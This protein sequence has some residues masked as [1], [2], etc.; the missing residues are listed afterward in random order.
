VKN[1]LRIFAVDADNTIAVFTSAERR[2]PKGRAARFTNQKQLAALAAHWPS[3]RLVEIWNHLPGVRKI[4][5][6][7][8][9][10]KGT[11][12]TSSRCTV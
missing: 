9:R 3:R 5:K 6:F 1:P 4:A 2:R 10:Q 8:N 7:T 12:R 11:V